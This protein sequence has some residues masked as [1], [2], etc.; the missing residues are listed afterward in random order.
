MA[1]DPGTA[2]AA[3]SVRRLAFGGRHSDHPEQAWGP[4]ACNVTAL[5]IA[6]D[7][8]VQFAWPASEGTITFQSRVST[9]AAVEYVARR[10]EISALHLM[11]E[12]DASWL[13]EY[14]D[15][16][17][18]RSKVPSVRSAG[19]SARAFLF[20][21]KSLAA[22]A[23]MNGPVAESKALR[24]IRA[25]LDD[26]RGGLLL[27]RAS[28]PA[29]KSAPRSPPAGSVQPQPSA[30][31]AHHPGTS[32]APSVGGFSAAPPPASAAPSVGGFSAAPPPPPRRFRLRPK[33]NGPVGG[34]GPSAAAA[35]AAVAAAKAAAA[36]LSAA[37]KPPAPQQQQHGA[38]ASGPGRQLQAPQAGAGPGGPPQPPPRTP[39]P[40]DPLADDESPPASPPRAPG[41]SRKRRH[42][43]RPPRSH[44][45]RA[46]SYTGHVP[47][48]PRSGSG[49]GRA[50]ARGVPRAGSGP[51]R[52]GASRGASR[53]GSG[54]GRASA[55]RSVPAPAPG[56]PAPGPAAP[57][58]LA[59]APGPVAPAPPAAHPAPP[60]KPT[61]PAPPA[62]HTAPALGLAAPAPFPALPVPAPGPP[63][64]GRG[65]CP[66]SPPSCRRAPP[67]CQSRRTDPQPRERRRPRRRPPPGSAE[68]APPEAKRARGPGAGGPAGA[69]AGSRWFWWRGGS[70]RGPRG[71]LPARRGPPGAPMHG[72][73]VAMMPEA[74]AT[75]DR[76]EGVALQAGATPPRLARAY[77]Y[78]GSPVWGLA[79]VTGRVQA[80]L[81]GGPLSLACPGV[82][83]P[84]SI[85]SPIRARY[86]LAGGEAVEG[87]VAI[88]RDGG[89]ASLVQCI[90]VNRRPAE[91][92]P[93][94]PLQDP[95]HA[96]GALWP[97]SGLAARVQGSD[98]RGG[99]Y[100]I[101]LESE[102][103][104]GRP[105]LTISV[106]D[107]L[108]VEH[109]LR[110]G[111][112]VRGGAAAAPE[113]G[114]GAWRLAELAEVC[115]AA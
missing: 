114:P 62:A 3:C 2:T 95:P 7:D 105:A 35:A 27:V 19:T 87:Y 89:S 22:A 96:P 24:A 61:A 20:T 77:A 111:D 8:L 65:E 73:D 28:G 29:C 115:L 101:V 38:P 48:S 66:P 113:L 30:A 31:S 47:G 13:E 83:E 106:P 85:E 99:A 5:P 10:Q 79:R 14:L 51:G 12:A 72:A 45:R 41:P 40:Y 71:D 52:A 67:L 21:A 74:A 103:Y 104:R 50:G 110:E 112:W 69:G 64:R 44:A 107:G 81:A 82:T 32:A 36:A 63:P 90:S 102:G 42:R 43:P 108:A 60:L 18:A 55:A 33:T 78:N 100:C 92:V 98:A 15:R 4:I 39:S 37:A 25:L 109:A 46:C 88:S 91:P 53:A 59:P 75:G 17:Q 94:L 11:R 93:A 49:P 16:L 70:C 9:A 58:Y 23:S 26:A 84:A 57:A 80:D 54:P 6:G 76:L 34:P 68:T 1:S 56:A 86:G 97:I